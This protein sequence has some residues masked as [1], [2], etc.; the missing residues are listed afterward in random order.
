M[1][2]ALDGERVEHRQEPTAVRA[3]L[4]D[5]PCDPAQVSTVDRTTD[6]GGP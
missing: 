3:R 2:I 5:L 4:L 1:R 6:C